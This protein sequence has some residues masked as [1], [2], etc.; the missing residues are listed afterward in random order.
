[1]KKMTGKW[2]KRNHTARN[3]LFYF[4]LARKK[5]WRRPP[6]SADVKESVTTPPPLPSQ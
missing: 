5:S 6:T 1:M 3:H 4:W 2:L